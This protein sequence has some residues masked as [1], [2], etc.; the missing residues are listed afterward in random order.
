MTTLSTA[1]RPTGAGPRFELMLAILGAVSAA[2]LTGVLDELEVSTTGK[3][4]GLAVG[5]ALPPFVAVAGPRRPVRV[6]AA[7]LLS[8]AAVVLAYGGWQIFAKVSGTQP[9]L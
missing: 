8:I 1:P 9:V 5:A 7:V 6:A 3:L 4:I 2:I